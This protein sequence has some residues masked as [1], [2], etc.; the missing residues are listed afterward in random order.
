MTGF[1]T[2]PATFRRRSLQAVLPAAAAIAGALVLSGIS[3]VPVAAEGFAYARSGN[4]DMSQCAAGKGPAVRLTVSGLKSSEGNL[5]VRAYPANRDDWLKSKRY[6]IR[7]DARPQPGT[8][9]VCVPL[10][11]PGEYAIAVHHDVNGNRKS[12]L[13]DGAGMSN[14]PGIRKILGL[15]PRPPSVEKTR[16]S[17]DG[18]VS[19]MSIDVQY[20]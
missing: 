9:A 7:I 3:A 2:A 8:M 14:N 11:A 13:S 16:F 18:G 1:P 19:R 15:V 20:M 10:P 5:F 6:V 17:I 4:N 12:D